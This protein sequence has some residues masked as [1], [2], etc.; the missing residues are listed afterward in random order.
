MGH[1]QLTFLEGLVNA[2]LSLSKAFVS[3]H[4]REHS[5]LVNPVVV[6]RTKEEHGKVPQVMPK[7]LDV[8]RHRPGTADLCRPPSENKSEKVK[9]NHSS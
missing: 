3:F 9:K 4:I 6:M 8:Q 7:A 5:A 2:S 1:S